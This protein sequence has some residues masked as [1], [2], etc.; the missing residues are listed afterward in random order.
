MLLLM[1]RCETPSG[2]LGQLLNCLHVNPVCALAAFLSSANVR[3]RKLVMS[4]RCS[5][6]PRLA[7][8]VGPRIQLSNAAAILR[9]NSRSSCSCFLLNSGQ[10]RMDQS[11]ISHGR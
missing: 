2:D 1:M 9:R 3:Q 6:L 5:Y 4:F 7:V 11:S 10:G 8:H